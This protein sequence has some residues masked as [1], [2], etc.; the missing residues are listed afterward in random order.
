MVVVEKCSVVNGEWQGEDE[1]LRTGTNPLLLT[2]HLQYFK[3][4]KQ[5]SYEDKKKKKKKKQG[6]GWWAK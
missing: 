5:L 4:R 2:L 1:D 3:N 6:V